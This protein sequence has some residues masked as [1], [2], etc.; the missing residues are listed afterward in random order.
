M[1]GSSKGSHDKL[2]VFYGWKTYPCQDFHQDLHQGNLNVFS[3]H[4]TV[5]IILFVVWRRTRKPEYLLE[6]DPEDDIRENVVFYDEEGAGWWK[7]LL[8]LFYM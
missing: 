7:T 3:L 4:H 2:Y 1:E 6:V 8:T 5:L